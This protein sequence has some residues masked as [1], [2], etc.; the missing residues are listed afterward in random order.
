MSFK[1][2]VL[3]LIERCGY[4][5]LKSADHQRLIGLQHAAGRQSRPQTIA[6]PAGNTP[7]AEGGFAPGGAAMPQPRSASKAEGPRSLLRQAL[8]AACGELQRA[9]IAGDVVT[10]GDG[11]PASL[12]LIGAAL[13]ALRETSRRLILLDV[14]VDPT[15]RAETELE[16]WGADIDPLA[17]SRPKAARAPRP[18]PPELAALPYPA[19]NIVVLH[20][21]RLPDAIRGPIAF[22]SLTN[23]RYPANQAW[24]RRLLPL[25]ADHGFVAVEGTAPSF[26][27]TDPVEL[28]LAE[29]DIDVSFS[30]ID[31]TCRLGTRR[32]RRMTAAGGA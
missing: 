21:P 8:T 2:A 4:V 10:C 9:G 7:P 18:L 3:R 14:S 24:I 20:Y 5:V 28:A 17:P 16:L 25:V 12:A 6:T 23:E 22:L 11:S 26:G 15:H 13:A 19:A 30:V 29:L 1:T 32:P 31:N 27:Q